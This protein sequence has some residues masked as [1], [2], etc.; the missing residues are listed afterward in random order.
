MSDTSVRKSIGSYTEYLKQRALTNNSNTKNFDYMKCFNEAIAL[1]NNGK[2]S[3]GVTILKDLYAIKKDPAVFKL[4]Q[5]N[6][7]FC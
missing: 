2:Q 6:R 3:D 7:A 5:E 4:I 1:I